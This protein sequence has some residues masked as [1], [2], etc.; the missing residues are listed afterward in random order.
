MAMYRCGSNSGGVT[1]TSIT[2]SNVTP[3]AM[4]S[5]VIYETTAA[6]YA[7]AS[8]D[9]KTPDDTTPPTVASGDIVKMGGA[10]YLYATQQSGAQVATGVASLTTSNLK[11]TTDFKPKKICV[12]QDNTT[13]VRFFVYDDDISTTKYRTCA[14]GSS[15]GISNLG[16]GSIQLVS[17]ENDGFIAKVG[18]NSYAGDYRY[19]VIG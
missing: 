6:G 3:A 15:A 10:G 12:Q 7:I 8:Y 17:I 5:G 1:P 11:I 16:T 2:P 19:F 14:S 13:N 9:S 4:S 18:V